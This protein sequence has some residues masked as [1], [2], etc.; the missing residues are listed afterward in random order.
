MKFMVNYFDARHSEPVHKRPKVTDYKGRMRFTSWAEILLDTEMYLQL[1]S[2]EPASA[3]SHKMTRF[4][5]LRY[6]Q[7]AT[8][9]PS[10]DLLAI[11]W[12]RELY[13]IETFYWHLT[14][15]FRRIS[16]KNNQ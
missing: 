13:V 5:N 12:H 2:F 10:C 15:S 1:P 8:V 7:C 16:V 4:R 14:L 3:S 9:K 11:R 6:P